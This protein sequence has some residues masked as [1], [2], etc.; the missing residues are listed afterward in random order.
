MNDDIRARL[1]DLEDRA[2]AITGKFEIVHLSASRY[3]WKTS[4]SITDIQRKAPDEYFPSPAEALDA[5]ER[6]IS[7]VEDRDGNLARTLGI[8]VPVLGTVAA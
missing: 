4:C 3:G 2:R 7:S 6:Q 1:G 8:D 5:I